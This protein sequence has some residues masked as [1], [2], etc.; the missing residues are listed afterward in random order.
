[1]RL[2]VNIKENMLWPTKATGEQERDIRFDGMKGS[3]YDRFPAN[4][5]ECAS[6]A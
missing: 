1:M 3:M 2:C 5:K 6:L 4:P